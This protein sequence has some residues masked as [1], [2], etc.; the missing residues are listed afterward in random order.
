LVDEM[1]DGCLPAVLIWEYRLFF[2]ELS[3]LLLAGAVQV[4][5][6]CWTVHIAA[7]RFFFNAVLVQISLRLLLFVFCALEA[8]K[9]D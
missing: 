2:I 8:I 9:E 7:G 5:F 3:R 4:V 6:F 1:V